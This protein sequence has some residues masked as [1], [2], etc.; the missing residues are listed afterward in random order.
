MNNDTYDHI[1]R[2]AKNH[3]T[4]PSEGAWE[5]LNA[6]LDQR[7]S[8]NQILVYRRLAIAAVMVALV[9]VIALMNHYIQDQNP[10]IFATNHS[11]Q[12]MEMEVI[13]KV[14]D[15]TLDIVDVKK[16][17]MAYADTQ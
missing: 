1:R 5:R 6:L 17:Y 4:K 2:E 13:G 14:T 11:G 16:L 7:D 10:N 12:P 3:K 9:S 8:K 15:P